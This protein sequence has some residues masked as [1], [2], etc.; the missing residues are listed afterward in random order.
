MKFFRSAA[1][2]LFAVLFMS[3]SA[4]GAERS[5]SVIPLTVT[6]DQYAGGR[7]YLPVRISNVMGTMRLDTGAS[8]TRIRLAPWNKDLPALGQS[9]S[10]GASGATMR[11][12]DVEAQ[13]F[14]LVADQGNNVARA[15]YQITRCPPGDA[16]DLLGLDFFKGARFSL[17]IDRRELVFFGDAIGSGRPK[18]FR[19]LGPEGNLVGVDLRFGNTAAV[20][21]FDTGA[22]VSAVDQQFLRR[23]KALFAPVNA[24]AQAS[25][26]GG[27]RMSTPVYRIKS[28][29]LGGG[30]V[31]H[32]LYAISY[33]FGAL[34]NALGRD[35]HF[36]IGYN[37]IR[38]F[39]WDFD[40]RTPTAPTWDAKLK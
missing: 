17:D 37:L 4:T 6:E 25:G 2:F 16:D 26:V 20:G 8:S 11:C 23:H 28:I 14:E 31:L 3:A 29:D 33:D 13:N 1:F 36:L 30:R 38:R 15:K 34:R 7:I 10:T 22:E 39:D 32:D 18:P 24:T 27:K 19:R 40:F 5:R 9:L 12:E 21:L 35:V